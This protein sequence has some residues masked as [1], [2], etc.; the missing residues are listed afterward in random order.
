MLIT[1][2]VLMTVVQ[3]LDELEK[4]FQ[5]LHSVPTVRL[6]YTAPRTIILAYNLEIR[7]AIPEQI[8]NS[9]AVLADIPPGS[10]TH[11]SLSHVFSPF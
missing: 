11:L 2:S 8:Q 4:L 5:N 10:R 6:E 3:L 9:L 1:A 7:L